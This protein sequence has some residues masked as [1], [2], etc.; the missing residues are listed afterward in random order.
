RSIRHPYFAR[1]AEAIG[2]PLL[3][4]GEKLV[5]IDSNENS[6]Q[7]PEEAFLYDYAAITRLRR[8]RRVGGTVL[9]GAVLV[10]SM[11][12]TDEAVLLSMD[13]TEQVSELFAEIIPQQRPTP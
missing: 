3:K 11:Q 13:A 10:V 5:G 6:D 12:Y 7:M 8:A 4:V 2:L 1:A 9:A